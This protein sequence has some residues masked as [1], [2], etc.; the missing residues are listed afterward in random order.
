MMF[1]CA[2]SSSGENNRLLSLL[3]GGPLFY[4]SNHR[5]AWVALLAQGSEP[6]SPVESHLPCCYPVLL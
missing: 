2:Q 6:A 5:V 4:L 1:F 3:I